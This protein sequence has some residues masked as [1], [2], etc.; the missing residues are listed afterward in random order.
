MN[1][2]LQA[3]KKDVI[4]VSTGQKT[5]ARANRGTL[6]AGASRPSD[7]AS[8]EDIALQVVLD[9]YVC[10]G[11]FEGYES[12][13]RAVAAAV[14]NIKKVLE[15][16]LDIM[17]PV[18]A[19]TVV[20]VLEA[21]SKSCLAKALLLFPGLHDATSFSTAASSSSHSD[22]S[23]PAIENVFLSSPSSRFSLL[24]LAMTSVAKTVKGGTTSTVD[25]QDHDGPEVDSIGSSLQKG[26]A[27]AASSTSM[28]A[29]KSFI[30]DLGN[31]FG[32]L[33]L[34]LG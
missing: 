27:S 26:I 3:L 23:S 9:L 20:P 5:R 24:P 33:G 22:A 32:K 14:R 19:Q 10:N 29:A 21:K 6:K 18:L 31:R 34:G 1:I 25:T 28:S 12:D 4:D 16:W 2:L 17:D 8:A 11:L 30:G 7:I 13:A 15:E